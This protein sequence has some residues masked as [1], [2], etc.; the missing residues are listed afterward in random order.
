MNAHQRSGDD[1]ETL[2]SAWLTEHAGLV[3]KVARAFAPADADRQDLI[4]D[5]LLQVWCSMPRFEGRAKVSTWIYRVAFNTALAWQRK[6]AK[7]G[8]PQIPLIEVEGLPGPEE[9][10]AR[11]L[12]EA[13]VRSTSVVV[14][15]FGEMAGAD[16]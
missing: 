15:C 10:T 14:K 11:W 3:F 16:S 2:F 6:E 7:H 9:D 4:Q 8:A 5:I 1:R 13:P 12:R